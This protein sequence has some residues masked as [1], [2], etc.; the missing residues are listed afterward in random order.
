MLAEYPKVMETLLPYSG[1]DVFLEPLDGNHGDRLILLGTERVMRQMDFRRVDDPHK[2]DLILVNGGGGLFVQPWCSDLHRFRAYA[3]GFIDTPMVVLP[4][5]FYWG[6]ANLA[7]CFARRRAPATLF[8]RGPGS[9]VRLQTAGLP[10]SVT[11]GLD[12]DMA[13]H[14]ADSP[15]IENARKIRSQGYLLLV[16]RFDEEHVGATAPPLTSF[17]SVRKCIP[18]IVQPLAR[19]VLDHM[20]FRRSELNG[21]VRELAC[22]Q[23][24]EL[25]DLPVVYNDVSNVTRNSFDDFVRIIAQAEAVVSTRLHVGILAAMLQKLTFLKDGPGDYR[26]LWSVY[27]QSLATTPHVQL[28]E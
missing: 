19:R 28:L 10:G 13:L 3:Q 24:P 9:L 5:S 25:R 23:R 2:A 1:A 26:K 6:N 7:E 4:S 21:V 11:L 22:A 16:E 12:H 20:R 17:Q 15:L 8:A 18:P 27:T 14:L